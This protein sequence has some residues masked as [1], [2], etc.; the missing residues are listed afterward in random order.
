MEIHHSTVELSN[1][2]LLLRDDLVFHLQQYQG[3]PCYLVEDELNSKF[4]RIGVSEYNFVSSLNGEV[5]VGQAIAA[6]ATQM[7]GHAI[8]EQD[9]ISVCKWLIDTGLATTEAS[10]RSGR[11]ID[12][13]NQTAAKK[14]IA[15]LNP[16]TPKFPLF[17]PDAMLWKLNAAIGWLFSA[18][19]VIAWLAVVATGVFQ[20]WSNWELLCSDSWTVFSSDNWLWF[21]V[22]WIGLKIIHELAHGVAC[23]RFDGEVRQ[24]GIVMILLIPLPF[25][26]VTSSWRFSS[27]WKRIFVA[28]AGMYAEMFIAAVAAIIWAHADIGPIKQH[29]FNVML[30]G[31]L[32]TLLFN[33]NPLM[34]FDGY[35]MLSD[36]LEMPNL[37][38]HGQQ[39]SKW[40]GKRYYLGL[41]AKKPQWPEG[42]SWIVASYAVLALIWKVLICVGLTLAAERL[43]FGA[44][45]ALAIVSICLWVIWPI[46]KLLNYV[47]V[48]PEVGEKPNALRFTMVTA[49]SV[50]GVWAVGAFLPWYSQVV[51]PAVIEFQQQSDIRPTSAGFLAEIFVQPNQL[52]KSGQVLALLENRD[53]ETEIR[54]LDIE[55]RLTMA[56]ARLYRDGQD[57]AAFDIERETLA[58]V[59]TRLDNRIQQLR[60]LEIKAPQDG[61]VI[62]DDLPSRRNTFLAPGTKICSVASAEKKEVLGLVA[63]EDFETFQAHQGKQVSV[64]VWGLGHGLT[65]TLKQVNPRASIRLPNPALASTAGGTLPVRYRPENQS[66]GQSPIE[67]VDPHFTAVIELDDEQSQHLFS[68]Q[69]ARVSFRAVK[70]SI[71]DVLW[72]RFSK[73]IQAQRNLLR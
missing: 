1:T 13:F 33:A 37:G 55:R 5:T 23:K 26:D 46:V 17:N 12:S 32:T 19:M 57:L 30:A 22:T 63:Q 52:V 35:Y 10:R 24:S 54:Q 48:G 40:L 69:R 43:I 62:A 47:Y 42:K 56:K 50:A 49:G 44:G 6:N 58:A 39:W 9:A 15:Q 3:E 25:V 68:G 16:L 45:I 71:G 27:K 11:L 51:A 64:H 34:R 28:A 59:E 7:G 66:T 4:F 72:L 60:E 21:A 31:S 14:Q 61:I 67:L 70:G 2:R 41:D 53:L 8:K 20:I 65:A 38:T 73:W 29:A 18:P 36:W